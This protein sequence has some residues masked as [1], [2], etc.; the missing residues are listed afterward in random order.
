MHLVRWNPANE[1]MNANNRLN[2]FFNEFFYPGSSHVSKEGF[3]WNPAADVYENDDAY[4]IKAELPGFDK[5]DINVDVKENILTIKG[6]RS[7]DN[8]VKEEKV[9]RRERF[10]GKF[11]RAFVLPSTVESGKIEA[12]FADGLL[13]IT[14]PKSVEKKPKQITIH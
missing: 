10:Q 5:K 13:K 7:D 11:Q 2:R 3:R 14:I 12:E 6:E 8:K 4:V 1:I 9:Y